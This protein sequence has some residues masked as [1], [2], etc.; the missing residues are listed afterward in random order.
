[1]S[2]KLKEFLLRWLNNTAGVL[3]AACLVNGIEYHNS[4]LNL[5][6]ASLLLGILYAVV[7]PLLLL[8]SLPLLVVTLGLF[9]FVINALLLQ[10]VGWLM[11]PYF[12]VAGFGPAFLGA[13]II[14]VVSLVLNTL[15]GTS[16]SRIRIHRGGPPTNRRDDGGDGPVIDI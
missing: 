4:L 12:F 15:T 5:A 16:S 13:L 10:F 11:R 3:I 9:T 1:M 7:R 2:P 14:F 6:A 8:L